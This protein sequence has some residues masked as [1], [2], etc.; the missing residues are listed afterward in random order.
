MAG[1]GGE[2]RARG[3]R[4]GRQVTCP[5]TRALWSVSLQAALPE[6]PPPSP[7]RRGVSCGAVHLSVLRPPTHPVHLSAPAKWLH[8][9]V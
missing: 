8:L 9:R 2:C 1:V 4:R 7:D 3:S 6:M 5:R